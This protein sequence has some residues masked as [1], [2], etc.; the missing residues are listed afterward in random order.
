MVNILITSQNLLRRRHQELVEHTIKCM[1]LRDNDDDFE[2]FVETSQV[3]DYN[4]L[5]LDELEKCFEDFDI[6]CVVTE[7]DKNATLTIPEDMT[8]LQNELEYAALCGMRKGIDVVLADTGD[9]DWLKDMVNIS[10][11]NAKKM[12]LY[13]FYFVTL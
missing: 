3:I 5:L 13:L 9:K 6:D 7:Y 12:D 4:L 11:E 10:L 1:S 2:D 8:A